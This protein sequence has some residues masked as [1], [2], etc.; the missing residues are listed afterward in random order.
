MGTRADFYVGRGLE[1]EYLG[2]IAWDG[3]PYD[4]HP[5]GVP[6]LVTRAK[7][8]SKYR[9]AVTAFLAGREDATKPA[10]GWPWPWENSS[11]TDYAYAFDKGR[12]FACALTTITP[13]S[14]LDARTHADESPGPTVTVHPAGED[15]VFG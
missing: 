1:A 14:M 12:V 10:Q 3:Y 8:E 7:S 4:R 15:V 13:E 2:S 11:T 5:G 9:E 6:L